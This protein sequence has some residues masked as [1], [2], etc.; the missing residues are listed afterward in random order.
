[1]PFNAKWKVFQW[2]FQRCQGLAMAGGGLVDSP[3][4]RV[5]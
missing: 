2:G 1:M 5:V 3:I 4:L